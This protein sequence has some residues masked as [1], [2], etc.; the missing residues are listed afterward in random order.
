MYRQRIATWVAKDHPFWEDPF[1]PKQ[2]KSKNR[3][4]GFASPF[5]ETSVSLFKDILCPKREDPKF[6]QV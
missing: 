2:K 6:L 4:P 3:W 1:E 5:L